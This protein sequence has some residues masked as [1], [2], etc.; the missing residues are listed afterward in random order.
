MNNTKYLLITIITLNAYLLYILKVPFFDQILNLM[1]SFGIFNHYK[2]CNFL[3]DRGINKSQIFLSFCLIITILYRSYWLHIG[4]NFIYLLL[5]SFLFIFSLVSN[6]SGNIILNLRPIFISLFFPISKILFIPLSII[7]T[8]FSTLFTWITLNTFG[9]SSI[10]KGQEIYHSSPGID[11]TFSCSGS[12]Q[13][14]FCLIAMFILY[15]FFPLKN[16]RLF[17]IQLSIAFLVTFS[18][19]VVRLFI[20]TI[21]SYTFDYEGFSIFRY[22]HGGNG[23]LFFSFFSI[24]ISCESYKRLYF[25]RFK[26]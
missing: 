22:L 21:Y 8:P 25:K 23:G 12:G 16:T 18:A 1:I 9:F 2:E 24:L 3:L 14:I 13:I 11:V 26:L 10:M 6:K 15:S 4:D 7:I 20:L 17:L 19:N 5:P